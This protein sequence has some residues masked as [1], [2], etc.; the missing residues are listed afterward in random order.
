[1][2]TTRWLESGSGSMSVLKPCAKH[3]KRKLPTAMSTAPAA[4]I[5]IKASNRVVRFLLLRVGGVDVAP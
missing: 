2:P 5:T 1:M 3:P 4:I